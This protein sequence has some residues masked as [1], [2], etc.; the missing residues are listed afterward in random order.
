MAWRTGAEL[1]REIWPQIKAR[2]TPDE[3]RQEFV[4]HLV[5]YFLECDVDPTDLQGLDP[6]IDQ[7]LRNLEAVPDCDDEDA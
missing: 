5:G 6:K 3:F 2:V 4:E 7:A 1:F